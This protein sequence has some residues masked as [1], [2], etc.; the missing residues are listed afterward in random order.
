MLLTNFFQEFQKF[1][2]SVHPIIIMTLHIRKA[3]L[4]N[5]R[6]LKIPRNSTK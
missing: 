2:E 3:A 1:Q 6:L 4:F 5:R